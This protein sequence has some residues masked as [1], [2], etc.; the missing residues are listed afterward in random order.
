MSSYAADSAVMVTP[1]F[2]NVPVPV[3]VPLP[4]STHSMV[5]PTDLKVLMFPRDALSGELL[6]LIQTETEPIPTSPD[7]LLW[8]L[9][10]AILN[11]PGHFYQSIIAAFSEF[12]WFRP[13]FRVSNIKVAGIS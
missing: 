4:A 8:S 2:V 12:F 11:I 10:R 5:S 1:F 13:A 3:Y 7:S 6:P 9:S